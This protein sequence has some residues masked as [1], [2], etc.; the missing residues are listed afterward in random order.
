MFTVLECVTDRH[1]RS[2]TVISGLIA[3][4]GMLAFHHLLLRAEES[5]ASRR[6]NWR[7]VAAFSAGL[8]VWATHF[9]AMLAYEGT[10]ALRFDL[11]FTTLSAAI[12]VV[13]FWLSIRQGFLGAS[14][15]VASA[16]LITLTVAAMHFVGMAGL[17]AEAHFDFEWPPIVVGT[18][19]AF[20]LF[21]LSLVLF[22]RLRG[23]FRIAA[24]AICSVLGVCTLHFVTMSATIITPD[25]SL[26][27][28]VIDMADNVW[29]TS[30]ITG[31]TLLILVSS[32]IGVV[33]D[34]HLVD[35]KG[36]A[37]S[38]L[39]GLAVVRDG[40]ILEVNA[41]FSALLD[42]EDGELIGRRADQFLVAIDGQ[43]IDQPRRSAVEASP[44]TGDHARIFEVAVHTIEYGGR[45]SE[46]IAVRDL[47]ERRAVQKKV[48]YLAR[49]DMLTGLTNR[50]IF[51]ESLQLQLERAALTGK[52]FALLALDLDR[53]KAVNDLFG[54]AEGDRVLRDVA[55]I[56]RASC[57]G[58]DTVA[59]IGGDEFVILTAEGV[60]TEGAGALAAR[61]R[62]TFR[63]RMNISLDPTAVGVSIGIAVFPKD[64]ADADALT[65]AADV[66]LYRAKASGRGMHA[67]Y[68]L[69]M[70]QERRDRR[71]LESELRQ[72]ISR[73]ELHLLFQPIQ[74]I[75]K[76]AILGY[77][78]L[79][80]WTHPVRGNVPPDVFIP[81]AEES[82][83][84]LSIGEWVLREACR[85]AAGWDL[86]LK[87]AVNMSAVQF[88]LPH[89]A[90]AIASVLDATGLAPAR[91]EL[92]ITETALL[93]DRVAT[94]DILRQIKALGVKVVMDD[95]GTGYSSLSNLQSFPFDGLKIDR[96]FIAEMDHDANARAIVR[97]VVS[98]GRSL[99]LPVT[100][101]GI[102]TQAQ[103]RMIVD[104]GCAHAQGYLFGKPD[105][106]PE[107][108]TGAREHRVELKK[109]KPRKERNTC[110]D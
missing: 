71:Q 47:T 84:I 91:L 73:N 74:S 58:G 13:G 77:E 101:E 80:R 19:V 104:E 34:R 44:R 4:L 12:A 60:D 16:G 36:F 78:A 103:Y 99:N 97:A 35:L 51:Q 10:V 86:A 56:L 6:R 102:E 94:L 52:P 20:A 46:V 30:A 54:H 45:P 92:E 22:S 110:L 89:L 3:L 76:A 5:T 41:K 7:L 100:A 79:L 31:V 83:I 14:S 24:P 57:R 108:F 64:G 66:A 8:S 87:V 37:N 88:R 107:T 1:D 68:D 55:G 2:I 15:M 82:G 63:E 67:F 53:F 81:I 65:Q 70:D 9:V 49:H 17:R 43:P 105:K 95:F 98:L 27:A 90:G 96:S 69:A 72:A 85:Q 48:E 62:T 23:P 18:V 21:I 38:T 39:D 40:I 93:K 61:I 26:P 32:A 25:P 29:L 106:G 33:I 11:M 109:T 28:I 42:R 59:R 50:S 75:D